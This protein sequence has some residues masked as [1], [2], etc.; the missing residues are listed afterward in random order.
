MKPAPFVVFSFS[1]SLLAKLFA[2]GGPLVFTFEQFIPVLLRYFPRDE[3]VERSDVEDDAIVQIG[4][5][6]QVRCPPQFV[7]EVSKFR[8][9][10]F[11]FLSFLGDSFGFFPRFTRFRK[12]ASKG[13]DAPGFQANLRLDVIDQRL[14]EHVFVEP[15]VVQP[16]GVV[17][18]R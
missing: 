14:E 12:L 9:E 1:H 7:L 11:L 3:F 5:E 4:F 2:D 18:L 8:E 17:L 10:V 16:E 13:F 15:V 6:M